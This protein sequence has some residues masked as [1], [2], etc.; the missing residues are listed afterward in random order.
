MAFLANQLHQVAAVDDAAAVNLYS[1]LALL[2]AILQFLLDETTEES[3]IIFQL[4]L[5]Q[6][7]AWILPKKLRENRDPPLPGPQS[8]DT[9]RMMSTIASHVRED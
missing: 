9:T 1:V 5:N 2:I 6:K 8:E 7:S 3:P 4:V